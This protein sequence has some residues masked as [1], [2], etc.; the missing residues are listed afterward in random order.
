LIYKD[1][2]SDNN[3]EQNGNYSVECQ[4]CVYP[5]FGSDCSNTA[6]CLLGDNVEDTKRCSSS[7]KCL[8]IPNWPEIDFSMNSYNCTSCEEGYIYASNDILR[9]ICD[10]PNTLN[11][12][13]EVSNC[14]IHSTYDKSSFTCEICSSGFGLS[15][16]NSCVSLTDATNCKYL[17]LQEFKYFSQIGKVKLGRQNLCFLDSGHIH[18]D[19]VESAQIDPD[20][21]YANSEIVIDTPLACKEFGRDP[22]GL[23]MVYN[24]GTASSSLVSDKHHNSNSVKYCTKCDQNSLHLVD[25]ITKK[26]ENN[27]RSNFFNIYSPSNF[28][29]SEN[30]LNINILPLGGNYHFSCIN[31]SRIT[32][33][34]ILGN[35]NSS[36]QIENCDYYSLFTYRLYLIETE[37]KIGLGCVKCTAGFTGAVFSDAEY[38]FMNSEETLFLEDCSVSITDFDSSKN[39]K[40]IGLSASI[41]EPLKYSSGHF[42]TDSNNIMVI[43][44]TSDC[45][46]KSFNKNISSGQKMEHSD[47]S[48]SSSNIQECLTKSSFTNLSSNCLVLNVL[49]DVLKDYDY[50]SSSR[51]FNCVVCKYGY[52][53]TKD[54][55]CQEIL[56][57]DKENAD[58]KDDYYSVCGQCAAGHALT[59]YNNN[60]N[61]VAIDKGNLDDFRYN[62]LLIYSHHVE[63][64]RDIFNDDKYDDISEVDYTSCHSMTSHPGHDHCKVYDFKHKKCV[65]CKEGFRF[66][67]FGICSTESDSVGCNDSKRTFN[68]DIYIDSSV[69]L[70]SEDSTASDINSFIMNDLQALMFYSVEAGVCSSCKYSWRNIFLLQDKSSSQKV[71]NH[72]NLLKNFRKKCVSKKNLISIL[73]IV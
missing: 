32:P 11:N 66:D 46:I 36:N 55:N 24:K 63:T 53:L 65:F 1:N 50:S 7:D 42:C 52:K 25:H 20:M 43:Y 34:S 44:T 6:T 14:L 47:P 64:T 57:C 71:K 19:L 8:S 62:N 15:Q 73:K 49:I 67:S 37:P 38:Q 60:G 10:N 18:G 16:S 26:N 69:T 12:F 27:T 45:K 40:Q 35:K 61:T 68:I 59:F 17:L 9:S 31:T 48:N 39:S 54:G 56:N 51:S 13:S 28:D 23:N 29:G 70:G 2:L 30:S 4:Q 58:Y 33:T 21:V 22:N 5:Y 3:N 72:I 41:S